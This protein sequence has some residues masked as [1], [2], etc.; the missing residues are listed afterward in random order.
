MADDL[1]LDM[2]EMIIVLIL[3]LCFVILV[4]RV[5]L[6]VDLNCTVECEFFC[7]HSY[8]SLFYL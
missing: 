3:C 4:S 1:L 5:E 8:C 2:Y 6:Y 7:V